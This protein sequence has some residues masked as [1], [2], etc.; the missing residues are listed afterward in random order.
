MNS[1]VVFLSSNGFSRHWRNL[2]GG[3]QPRR[4]VHHG[5]SLDRGDYS[6]KTKTL[7]SSRYLP[8]D[9]ASL[10]LANDR[11]GDVAVIPATSEASVTQGVS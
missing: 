11:S 8:D 7:Q 1:G 4:A 6:R 2:R 10:E 3:P 5:T 9:G